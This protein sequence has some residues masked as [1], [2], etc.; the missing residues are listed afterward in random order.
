M[1]QSYISKSK[2]LEGLQCHK[3]IW[4][5]YNAKDQIPPIDASTQAIFDQG[6][7]V[8]SYAKKLFPD[9]IEI[10]AKPWQFD[11]IEKL[12]M[13]ALARRVPLFEA[14]LAYQGAFARFDILNPAGEDEWDLVEVK[15]STEVKEVNYNDVSIQYYIC[16]GAGLKIRKC[17]VYYINN[18]Y[19]RKG[20]ID[21]KQLFASSDV[22]A[23]ALAG[24]ADVP[25]N[26]AEIR[27]V[28]G[29]KAQ[30]DIPIGPWCDDPYECILKDHCWG[31]LP[32]HSV[33]TLNRSRK[34]FEWFNAGILQLKDIPIDASLTPPQ[35]IQMQALLSGKTHVDRAEIKSFLDTLRYPLYFLDFETI[36]TAIPLYD[37]L[38][39]YQ[40]LPFQYSLHVQKSP[41]DSPVHYGFLAD[42]ASD[43]RPTILGNL[44]N[45]LG[46]TGSIVA[47]NS[48]FEKGVLRESSEV[49]TEFAPW[50]AALEQRIVDLLIPFRTFSYYN[51]EQEGSASLKA[52]LPSLT[53]KGYEGMPIADGGAASREYLRVTY[54]PV[55]D[56]DRASIRKQ[57]EDYCGYDT[58]AM[59]SVLDELGKLVNA[60]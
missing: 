46:E 37:G 24:Q 13:S 48:S 39:P 41:G 31:F 15:S 57:L 11:M 38:R 8:G 18:Q 6:H 59:I 45:L 3:L 35:Q 23:E 56:G 4:F 7:L 21:P 52:V 9:G 12:S 44:K 49:F 51:P 26:L 22:T 10:K 29:Q 55:A 43:P 20:E 1:A 40:K 47:Y 60:T 30:P 17:V 2:Y 50:Y 34:G 32:E 58:I 5:R 14:G 25:R 54:T 16:A 28:I 27:A 36:N 53:G 33:F 19:V 42:G